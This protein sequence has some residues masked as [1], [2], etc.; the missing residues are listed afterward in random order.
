MKNCLL[1]SLVAL[2]LAPAFI[3]SYP[4]LPFC[5]P[6]TYNTDGGS[7]LIR[8]LDPLP[9]ANFVEVMATVCVDSA[10][11][12]KDGFGA[13]VQHTAFSFLSIA[14]VDTAHF[15]NDTSYMFTRSSRISFDTTLFPQQILDSMRG[16]VNTLKTRD[17]LRNAFVLIGTDSLGRRCVTIVCGQCLWLDA[18][19]NPFPLDSALASFNRY[20]TQNKIPRGYNPPPGDLRLG[21]V[22][23]MSAGDNGWRLRAWSDTAAWNIEQ[24]VGGGDCP[25]GCTEYTYKIYRIT[26]QGVV[27]PVDST[28]NGIL[29][30]LS[31]GRQ[32]TIRGKRHCL[33]SI[34]TFEIFDC[35]G[36]KVENGLVNPANRNHGD[37]IYFIRMR[38]SAEIHPVAVHSSRFPY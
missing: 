28:G 24:Y 38:G 36:R 9:G 35:F 19:A 10:W 37:G 1:F 30:T 31:Q 11:N 13:W 25:A 16:L 33:S 34:S 26:S 15:T 17:T 29:S 7:S 18:S 32:A 27:T 22:F 14:K 3:H 4:A 23:S 12:T 5:S 6:V 21:P 2:A 20:V 8:P